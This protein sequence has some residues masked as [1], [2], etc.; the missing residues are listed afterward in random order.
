M[1]YPVILSGGSGTRLWP[2][3]R[4][5]YPKQLLALTGERSLLQETAL[6]GRRRRRLRRAAD[7]RQ[8]GAPLHHRRAAARDRRRAGSADPRAG[9]PQHRPGRLRR[10][11]APRGDAGS[12]RPGPADAGHAVGPRDRRS[13]RVPAG[14]RARR[15][16]GARRLSR[17]ASASR[18]SGPRPAT[19]TSP[20]AGRS[21][22]VEGAFAV[23]RLC[24]EAGPGDRRALCRLGRVFLEQRHLSVS[25]RAVPVRAGAAAARHAGGVQGGA[26]RRARPRPISS[27]ST[28][29]A[30]AACPSDSIDY[31]VME[32]THAAAVVPVGMGWSDLGS[33][34]A[35]WEMGDKDERGNA[36]SRQRRRRGDRATA[37]CA[38]RPGWSRRSGSR[39]SSSSRPT[40]RS[41]SRRA[42]ARRR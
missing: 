27:A 20:A 2:M 6:P 42:T 24:R 3:S 37:I 34:D 15:R 16:G 38:R 25:G 8:R 7:R 31:A 18:R 35:L 28:R 4:S 36:L 9:R 13:R 10:G 5:L 32:H 17:H 19:A 33:W 22:G 41:W 30:F 12:G 40:T 11:A 14:D 39:T 26:R 1:I 23:D 21:T 29:T